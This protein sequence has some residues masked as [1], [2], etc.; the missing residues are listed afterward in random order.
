MP[1]AFSR[2]LKLVRRGLTNSGGSLANP[3][4]WLIDLFGGS[5]KANTNVNTQTSMGVAAFFNGVQLIASGLASLPLGVFE[6]M[7]DGSRREAF[8]H[9]LYYILHDQPNP[10]MTSMSFYEAIIFYT[11]IKGNGYATIQRTQGFDVESVTLK[12]PGTVTPYIHDGELFYMVKNEITKEIEP[13]LS[14]DILHIKGLGYNGITG[15]SVLEIA[16]ETL[17]G[18]I[19]VNNFGNEYF[20]N[21]GHPGYAV[22]MPGKLDPIKWK[23]IK[24][25]WREKV[26]NHDIAPLDGGMKLHRLGIPNN[27]A[28]FLE[29][30]KFNIE[31][32]ARI[33]NIPASKL[34]HADKPSY[35]NVEQENINFVV[36]CLRPWAKRIE[37]E[38]KR[39]LFRESE[40]GRFTVKFNLDGLLR[41]DVK[42][43]A[44]YYQKLFYVGALSPNDIRRFENMNP[45]EDGDEYFIPTNMATTQMLIDQNQN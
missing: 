14:R 23:H 8:D 21:G 41:G 33:L 39:K 36:D 34:K 35:N 25:T 10:Y 31:E 19:A 15:K 27:D 6:R 4:N 11:I 9:P 24:D 12:L 32:V 2:F 28:Q 16:R 3:P 38:L 20:G 30:K 17:A 29:S 7:S 40:L 13:M 26:K 37:G 22:E 5:T 1:N 45:R 18:A 42:T 43:R 44:E